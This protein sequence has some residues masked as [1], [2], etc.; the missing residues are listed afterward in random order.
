[1]STL[2]VGTI[3]SVSSAAPV[4]QNTSGTEK[5]QLAKAWINFNG[6]GTIAIRDS[7]NVSSITD[8]GTGNFEVTYQNAMANTNYVGVGGGQV[9]ND[10]SDQNKTITSFKRL[11]TSVKTTSSRIVTGLGNNAGTGSDSVVVCWVVFGDN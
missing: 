11:S 5:G 8:H 4:F 7:F 10:G 1:M 6:S 2:A 9:D 3:K